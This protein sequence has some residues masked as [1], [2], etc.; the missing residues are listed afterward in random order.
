MDNL[1]S[2][3]RLDTEGVTYLG[4]LT[5]NSL[6]PGAAVCGGVDVDVGADVAVGGVDTVVKVCL[7]IAVPGCD[8]T[9]G[10]RGDD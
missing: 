3:T 2:H 9:I 1:Y 8:V 7:N 10:K 5:E 6:E 4:I